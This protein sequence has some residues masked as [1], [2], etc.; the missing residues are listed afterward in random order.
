MKKNRTFLFIACIYCMSITAAK[1]QLI[2]YDQITTSAGPLNVYNGWD[3]NSSNCAA[4]GFC[5]AL[6]PCVQLTNTP[7]NAPVLYYI[8]SINSITTSFGAE[9][10]GRCFPVQTLATT[11]NVYL[12]FLCTMTSCPDNTGT[13]KGDMVRM[14]GAS[15][16]NVAA[17][18]NATATAG[19]VAFRVGADGNANLG[20]SAAGT[21]FDIA[22]NTFLLILKFE[23]VA[24]SGNDVVKLFVYPTTTPLAALPT[25]EP[26]TPYA[27]T[28]HSAINPE[29]TSLKG[30]HINTFL[31]QTTSGMPVCNLGA[32]RVTTSWAAISNSKIAG[33]DDVS[34]LQNVKIFPQPVSD[35]ATIEFTSNASNSAIINVLDASGRVVLTENAQIT[36]ASNRLSFSTQHLVSGLYLVRINN[37]LSIVTEKFIKE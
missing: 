33:V 37:G 24:G 18:V 15:A 32:F 11:P 2:F 1:A 16:F 3:N 6:N 17:R 13:L 9:G 22:G 20:T 4:G 26:T 25:T 36:E 35:K 8:N 5:N 21:T 7:I 23:S 14:I 34:S 31:S 19:K 10:P 30:F 29:P 12:S 27:S 28:T